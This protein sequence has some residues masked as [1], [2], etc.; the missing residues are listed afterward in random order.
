MPSATYPDASS[1]CSLQVKQ[2]MRRHSIPWGD[3]PQDGALR[4]AMVVRAARG[5]QIVARGAALKQG[6]G[7]RVMAVMVHFE[8]NEPHGFEGVEER[9]QHV[10]IGAQRAWMGERAYS[11]SLCDQSQGFLNPQ[12][13]PGDIAGDEKVFKSALDIIGIAA[14]NESV[15]QVRTSQRT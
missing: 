14:S 1:M 3:L 11:S 9:I 4:T 5:H 2:D 12:G 13:R 8:A 7:L 10:W 6:K 15:G